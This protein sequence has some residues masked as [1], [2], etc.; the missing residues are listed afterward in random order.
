M[1]D[2]TAENIMKN[3]SKQT[4]ISLSLAGA[5]GYYLYTKLVKAGLAM[6]QSDSYADDRTRDELQWQPAP[7]EEEYTETLFAEDVQVEEEE[8]VV[9]DE[10]FDDTDEDVTLQLD[11]EEEEDVETVACLAC[12]AMNVVGV[13]VCAFCGT[14][15]GEEAAPVVEEEEEITMPTLP[16][17]EEEPV[18][19]VIP[20]IEEE[21]PEL[22]ASLDNLDLSIEDIEP[23][24]LGVDD[25]LNAVDE[26][27]AAPTM[28]DNVEPLHKVDNNNKSD[29]QE[30]DDLMDFMKS[31]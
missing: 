29:K 6:G 12:G 13:E 3:E 27:A 5:I 16:V 19:P 20:V 11:E 24:S 25:L 28:M 7:V 15:M 17:V 22:D 23:D 8:P 30:F 2:N 18:A 10:L 4:L 9:E 21:I 14:K 31:L 26:T 1:K